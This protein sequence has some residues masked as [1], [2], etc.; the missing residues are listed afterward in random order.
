M[1]VSVGGTYNAPPR[2]LS[3]FTVPSTS[4]TA[5]YPTH[6]GVAP[7]LLPSSGNSIKPAT[8]VPEDVNRL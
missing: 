1:L 3:R 4:S 2:R 8:G 7:I 6:R 5:T